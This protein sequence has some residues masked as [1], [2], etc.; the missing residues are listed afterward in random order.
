MSTRLTNTTEAEAAAAFAFDS[1]DVSSFGNSPSGRALRKARET[2]DAIFFAP[3]EDSPSPRPAPRSQV[4]DS[5]H[6]LHATRALTDNE[7]HGSIPTKEE[8]LLQRIAQSIKEADDEDSDWNESLNSDPQSSVMGS[9][10]SDSSYEEPKPKPSCLPG[11]GLHQSSTSTPLVMAKGSRNSKQ[12]IIDNSC[13]LVSSSSISSKGSSSMVSA[14]KALSLTSEYTGALKGTLQQ[15]RDLHNALGSV[16][17]SPF[18]CS[19][20]LK[21]EYESC[22]ESGLDRPAFR[23][24]HVHTYGRFDARHTTREVKAAIHSATWELRQPLPIPHCDG[25]LFSVPTWRLGGPAGKIVCKKAFVAA[26]GGT[27][28]AHR[29][30]LALTIAGK[31]PSDVVALKTA[32]NAIKKLEHSIGPKAEWCVSW[33]RQHLMFQDWLPNEMKIQYRGPYWN[34]V[35]KS[36]YQPLA[37]RAKLLLKP[38]QWMRHRKKAIA[39]LQDEFFP[40]VKDKKLTVSRSA[41]HSKFP[42]CTDCQKYRS[43]Y[44][45]VVSNPKSTKEQTE[46]AYQLMAAHASQWQQDRETAL[47]LRH[48]Y[49]NLVGFWRYSVDDK[50]GSF[51]Q[52]LP[53]SPTGRDTK[54]NAKDKYR[55]SVHANVVCGVGGFKQF[56]FVPKNISTGSNFGLTSLLMT[57]Y[58]AVQMGNLKADTRNFVRHTDGGPDNV[59]VVSHFVHWLLVYLG[60]FDNILWFRFKAGHSHTEVADRLFSIIKRLFEADGAH[61]VNPIE[62]FPELVDKIEHEFTNE[63]ESCVFYWN[64]ANFDLRKMMAEMNC[65]SSKLSGISSKMVYQ[66]SYDSTFWEHGGVRVQYKSNISWRGNSRDAEWSPITR[67]WRTMSTGDEGDEAQS[68]ECNVSRPG[69][70]RFVSKPP[71]LRVT[72][73]REPFDTKADKFGPD[74]QCQAILNKRSEDLSPKSKSFWKCLSK[75][76]SCVGD[77]A[78]RVPD[79]PHAIHTENDSFTFD[80]SPKPFVDVMKKIMLRFPRPLLGQ[81]DPFVTAPAKTWEEALA[82]SAQA[83]P[84]GHSSSTADGSTHSDDAPGLR[85]PRRENSVVDMEMTEAERRRNMRE[86]A[87][88]DFAE[89]TPTRVEEVNL[90]ELYLCELEAA[91]HGIRL[92]L[93]MTIKEGPLS[94]DKK[95]TWTVAWFKIKSKKGWRTKNITFEQYK[96][97]G[98]RA[99]DDLELDSFRLQID[100]SDLT[101][102]GKEKK[103]TTPKFTGGFTEKILAFARSQKLDQHE[104][105]DEMDNVSDGSNGDEDDEDEDDDDFGEADEREPAEDVE[106]DS[107]EIQEEE[108]DSSDQDVAREPVPTKATRARRH[109]P[110]EDS[111][112]DEDETLRNKAARVSAARKSKETSKAVVTHKG[113]DKG[114]KAPATAAQQKK[115]G[116]PIRKG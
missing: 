111:S 95:P 93:G 114:S 91:E 1:P 108:I 89:N 35:Y 19:C 49:S 34:Q 56:T 94:D 110:I 38:A 55:F 64:F 31:D 3:F 66:Y 32:S 21:G 90:D 79:L 23:A 13:S 81:S 14:S 116:R 45:K 99:T 48:R 8:E 7:I 22:L 17:F 37:S 104:T 42:E 50:C 65:V 29:E 43:Q 112:D 107:S 74:K 58:T 113:K 109:I 44:K 73:R 18:K 41:R 46:A 30:A 40:S 84:A 54:E 26:I 28:H 4:V 69:G 36:F 97:G 98:K 75:F 63:A 57:I 103:D 47:D 102:A 2:C 80:G 77:V 9:V 101:A 10:S 85:D 68:V 100:E 6:S 86:L 92:G 33:W 96:V 15:Q 27:V 78:E 24:L 61:R 16:A 71:D 60:V 20:S 12:P 53:V 106:E 5:A 59:S 51:W 72:P 39:K 83:K 11:P 115:R 82:Q 25:R 88:E 76:H 105:E 52:A 87:E 62:S 70:V 67:A